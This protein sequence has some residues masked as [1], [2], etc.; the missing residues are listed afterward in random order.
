LSNSL[1]TTAKISFAAGA[2]N[3]FCVYP[4]EKAIYEEVSGNVLIDGGPITVVGSGVTGY[5]TFSAAMGEMYA[6]TNG[7]AQLYAQNL[8][9]GSSAST[10]IVA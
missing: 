4:A 9:N 2:K 6:N 8:S 10:D 1:S 3:V 7:F 5:T